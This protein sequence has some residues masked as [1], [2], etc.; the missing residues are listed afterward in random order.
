MPLEY[1][2]LVIENNEELNNILKIKYLNNQFFRDYNTNVITYFKPK[3]IL[4]RNNY[5][6]MRNI[7]G[8]TYPIYIKTNQI[9]EDYN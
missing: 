5:L 6:N 2:E 8:E 1:K 7:T 9:A 4:P 3:K